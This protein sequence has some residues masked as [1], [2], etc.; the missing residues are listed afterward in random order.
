MPQLF[1]IY[2]WKSRVQP[3]VIIAAPVALAAFVWLP[4]DGITLPATGT[5]LV[6]GALGTLISQMVRDIGAKKEKDLFKNWGGAPTTRL[7]RHSEADDRIRFER[8]RQKLAELTGIQLP[9]ADEEEQ[10]PYSA[11]LVYG[12]AVAQ[13]RETTRDHQVVFQENC[14]YGFRRNLW[15]L[16]NMSFLLLAASFVVTL[17]AFWLL[18]KTPVVYLALGVEGSLFLV[19]LSVINEAWV[20]RAAEG[21]ARQ[22]FSANDSLDIR[23]KG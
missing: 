14:N 23:K 10:Y 19:W 20:R 4:K 1:D 11:D 2:A 7:L 16:R 22:L 13:L 9:T 18:P 12:T 6:W 21:Y 8:R 5:A 17:L 15:A 3:A